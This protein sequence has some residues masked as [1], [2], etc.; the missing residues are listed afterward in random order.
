MNE[1]TKEVQD[2]YIDKYK[3]SW[4]KIKKG[5]NKWKSIPQSCSQDLIL[6]KWQ[7]SSN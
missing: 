3:A 1:L 4:L 7:H 2:L 5:L 6:L